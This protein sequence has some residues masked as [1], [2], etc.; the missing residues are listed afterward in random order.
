MNSARPCN[1]EWWARP[2][3]MG[4]LGLC[5]HTSQKEGKSFPI[6]RLFVFEALLKYQTVIESSSWAG[7]TPP[8]KN[9]PYLLRWQFSCPRWRW[10]P[11][12]KSRFSLLE[13][14]QT[15]RLQITAL[16]EGKHAWGA[17]QHFMTRKRMHGPRHAHRHQVIICEHGQRERG[18]AM[19]WKIC[20]WQM[21]WSQK[22]IFNTVMH[23]CI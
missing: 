2:S 18:T 14:Q 6:H 4:A 11:W 12:W 16:C 8:T 23:L 15:F 5:V 20:A 9:V 7:C 21:S 19:C 17:C 22:V 10:Q 13:E 3:H 1:S